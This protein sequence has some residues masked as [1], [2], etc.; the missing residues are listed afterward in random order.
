MSRDDC[1]LLWSRLSEFLAANLGLCFGPERREDLMRAMACAAREFGFKAPEAC[2]EWLLSAPLTRTQID[3]LA[4]QLTVGETYFYRYARNFEVLESDILPELIAARRGGTR[5]LRLWSAGCCTGE[6]PYTLAIL[7]TR[8][9][10]DWRQWRIAILATDINVRFLEQASAGIF[11]EWSFRDTPPG[12]KENYFHSKGDGRYEILPYLKELVSFSYLNLAADTYPSLL[13]NTNAMDVV[14]CRN[15]LMY[16]TPVLAMRVVGQLQRC[17][18]PGGWLMC[19]PTDSS[20]VSP[21]GLQTVSFPGATVY[22]QVSDDPAAERIAVSPPPIPVPSSPVALSAARRPTVIKPIARSSPKTPIE[23]SLDVHVEALA[24]YQ[25]GHY[26]E[27]GDRLQELLASRPDD[28]KTLELLARVY[29][30]QGRLPEAAALSERAIAADKLN[31]GIYYLHAAILQEQGADDDAVRCLNRALYL[32]P[33]FV[34]AH[35]SLASM[36]RAQGKMTA[37]HKCY[38]QALKSLE[39]YRPEELVPESD[40]AT[41]GRMREMISAMIASCGV[42]HA[43]GR[44]RLVEA[45]P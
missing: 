22:R 24:L 38:S 21:I 37:A 23:S 20:A 2:A 11:R 12:F 3:I 28:A 9:I 4:G 42:Q 7:L 5:S 18:L 14:L 25:Q 34:L 8:M 41:A 45:R 6:E 27:A 33:N 43:T 31:A 30:D 17:L 35:F 40:G 16:F 36:A 15:V 19:S 13:N 1:E 26:A 32:D 10:P 44:D 39:P 29:A